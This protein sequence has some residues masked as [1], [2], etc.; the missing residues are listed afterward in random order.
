L[1]VHSFLRHLSWVVCLIYFRIEFH[2][3][4]RVPLE[5]PV[6]LAPNHASY[7]D[8]VWVSIPIR[9]QLR[10]MTWERFFGFPLLGPMLR[11]LGAFPVRMEKGDRRA[12]RHS[13]DHL[14]S[15]GGL[16]IF[17]EGARTRTGEMTRFKPGVIQLALA[18]GAK[19]VPVTIVGG[20]RALSPHN[21][22]PRPT[23]VRLYYHDPVTVNELDVETVTKEQLHEEASR[24]RGIV[25]AGL[26]E[27]NVKTLRPPVREA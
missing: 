4:E 1:F 14:K 5:G 7:F 24:L 2:G 12:M 6:I 15:G 9:R 18:S 27:G 26:G 3:V 10:Y 22:V 20:Y 21:R 17:P 19:I 25:L 23:K 8:P 11:G 16:M 13:L